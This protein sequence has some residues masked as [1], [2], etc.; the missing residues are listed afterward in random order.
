MMISE[1]TPISIPL[2]PA[3]QLAVRG[4]L[5]IRYRENVIPTVTPFRKGIQQLEIDDTGVSHLLGCC[6]RLGGEAL[7]TMGVTGET[8]NLP[9]DLRLLGI[10]SFARHSLGRF[11]LF[12]N[13]TG[14]NPA[15]TIANINYVSGLPDIAAVVIAPLFYLQ[16]NAQIAAHITDIE[17]EWGRKDLPLVVYTNPDKHLT[18]GL[19]LYPDVLESIAGSVSGIKASATELPIIGQYGNI[20]ETGQGDEMRIIEALEAGA[21]FAVSSIGQVVPYAQQLFTSGTYEEMIGFQRQINYI[22]MPLT[23]NRRKIPAALKY[24]LALLDVCS[25]RIADPRQE[26]DFGE[27]Q[28]IERVFRQ[29]NIS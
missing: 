17:K 8:V 27:K 5:N 6:H 14:D 15:Q 24:Y 9:N 20:V 23:A 25:P 11:R 22:V 3:K 18:K 7:L 1:R 2:C 26:L 4:G 21:T 10:E 28:E 13:A 19:P 16:D 12:A 29:L